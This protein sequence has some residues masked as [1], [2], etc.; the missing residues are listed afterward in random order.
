[1]S[2]GPVPANARTGRSNTATAFFMLDIS[3]AKL[4][5]CHISFTDFEYK[6]FSF[7]FIDY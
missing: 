2:S 7:I 5:G 6:Q 4:F 3:H 1:M